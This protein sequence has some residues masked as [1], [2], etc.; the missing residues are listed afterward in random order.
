MK[1]YALITAL[2]LLTGCTATPTETYSGTSDI[3]EDATANDK[4]VD[5]TITVGGEL[6][7]GFSITADYGEYGHID[8][9]LHYSESGKYT[10][11]LAYCYPKVE[12]LEDFIT[13]TGLKVSKNDMTDIGNGAYFCWLETNTIPHFNSHLSRDKQLEVY[14]GL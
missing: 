14:R 1:R 3:F 2:I 9:D 8:Y 13:G 4:S 12:S 10:E 7:N 11:T 5:P 6:E